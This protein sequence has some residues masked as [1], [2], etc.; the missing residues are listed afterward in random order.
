M[1][2]LLEF[3]NKIEAEEKATVLAEAAAPAM[4]EPTEK[5]GQLIKRVLGD[6]LVWKPGMSKLYRDTRRSKTQRVDDYKMKFIQVKGAT[7]KWGENSALGR[8]LRS[9]LI[10]A[11][12]NVQGQ[13]LVFA[14]EIMFQVRTPITVSG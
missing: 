2:T 13:V 1:K 10:R 8:K 3:I 12:Y 9:E 5:A 7:D 14:D 6:K 11:G 4:K